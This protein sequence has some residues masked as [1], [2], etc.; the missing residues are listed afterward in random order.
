MG[1]IMSR[2]PTTTEESCKLVD[3]F[4]ELWQ[5][6]WAEM[7]WLDRLLWHVTI[8]LDRIWYG[9]VRRIKGES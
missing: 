5:N 8:R 2:R 1:A 7:S 4:D 9:I 3:A 6:V